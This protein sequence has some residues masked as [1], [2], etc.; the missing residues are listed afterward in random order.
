MI[1]NR[2][3]G[4]APVYLFPYMYQLCDT[5]ALHAST[6]HKQESD[7]AVSPGNGDLEAV[8]LGCKFLRLVRHGRACFRG[9]KFK[10]IPARTTWWTATRRRF[11]YIVT[12]DVTS[13][14]S[15]LLNASAS[16]RTLSITRRQG[17]CVPWMRLTV[18]RVAPLCRFSSPFGM[19]LCQMWQAAA[20]SPAV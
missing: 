17:E 1:R 12:C 13:Y 3:G 9:A 4:I 15:S 2:L 6:K 14:L 10:A 11:I 16:A 20:T 5:C 18:H 8:S 19:L 7:L